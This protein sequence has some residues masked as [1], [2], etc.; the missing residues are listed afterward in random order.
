M[1][2]KFCNYKLSLEINM[3]PRLNKMNI[4]LSI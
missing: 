4:E 3:V 2:F 1:K